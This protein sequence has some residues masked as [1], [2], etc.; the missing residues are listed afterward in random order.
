MAFTVQVAGHITD[1]S[2]K[3]NFF[4]Q[5]TGVRCGQG[6]GTVPVGQAASQSQQDNNN[7]SCLGKFLK[8]MLYLRKRIL[9]IYNCTIMSIVELSIF[10][11]KRIY[12]F[13]HNYLIV[14]LIT[15][16]CANKM[17]SK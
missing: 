4:T 9:S 10:L 2:F 11:C 6:R 8:T 13:S 15:D 14:I 1:K 16:R 5:E 7:P 17:G 3:Y 12:T